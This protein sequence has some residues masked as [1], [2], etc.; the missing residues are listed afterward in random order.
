ML[1]TIAA[2]YG[3]GVVA[4]DY[5]SIATVTVGSG[6]SSSIVFSSIPQTYQHLQIRGITAYP[7]SANN[8][9]R[10]YFNSDT[11]LANYRNHYLY[12][13]GA[14][15]GS[16]TDGNSANQGV[17]GDSMT[18]GPAVWVID[19]LDYSNTNK[20]TT[21]RTLNGYD[22]NGSGY[23]WFGSNLWMNTAAITNIEIS[24]VGTIN[25]YSQ[26]ALYGIKG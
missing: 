24:P 8:T 6:G 4:G 17:L 16:G 10:F 23:I 25:Q 9:S 21:M 18:V 2:I 26:F 3:D 20:N 12:G 14:A 11:T 5:Q 15:V 22:R 1:N 13:S 19:I 7:S